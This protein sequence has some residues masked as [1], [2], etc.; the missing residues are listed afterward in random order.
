MKRIIVT[1]EE[2]KN[3]DPDCPPLDENFWHEYVEKTMVKHW[4]FQRMGCAGIDTYREV[5]IDVRPSINAVEC[6]QEEEE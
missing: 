3:F 1:W 4:L 6:Q 2:F 5:K